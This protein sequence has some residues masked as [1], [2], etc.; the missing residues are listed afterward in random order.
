[1]VHEICGASEQ[2]PSFPLSC[3]EEMVGRRTGRQAVEVSDIQ[4]YVNLYGL[5]VGSDISVLY[6]DMGIYRN[7][8][9]MMHLFQH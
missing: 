6:Y 9:V 4:A 2:D 7:T 5:S 3:L 8:I 1:V